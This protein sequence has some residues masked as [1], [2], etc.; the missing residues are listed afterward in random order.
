MPGLAFALPALSVFVVLALQI[1]LLIR[2]IVHSFVG[3][4]AASALLHLI[5]ALGFLALELARGGISAHNRYLPM[6][7]A[8][9]ILGGLVSL[10]GFV[11]LALFLLKREKPSP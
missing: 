2:G 11:A 1:Y 4:F 6:L 7:S 9:G 3:L 8:F 10:A 5:Q